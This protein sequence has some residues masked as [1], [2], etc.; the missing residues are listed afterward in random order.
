MVDQLTQVHCALCI[1]KLL[2]TDA[3]EAIVTVATRPLMIL[4]YNVALD[5]SLY[6]ILY[7]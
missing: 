4:V 3:T 7:R 2:S 6:I 5:L 1:I